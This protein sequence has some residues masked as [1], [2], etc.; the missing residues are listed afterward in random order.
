MTVALLIVINAC[1]PARTAGSGGKHPSERKKG[2]GQHDE[3]KSHHVDRS[4]NST[5]TSR[6]ACRGCAAV[7]SAEA[8]G[9]ASA[10]GFHYKRFLETLKSA[11]AADR[12]RTDLAEVTEQAE[13]HSN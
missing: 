8:G 10:L 1:A 3:R 11:Q 9:E 12:V 13:V 4:E 6:R 5:G 2:R 7:P